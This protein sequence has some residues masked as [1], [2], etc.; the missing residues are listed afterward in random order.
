VTRGL[1]GVTQQARHGRFHRV[2]K[3][4]PRA[5]RSGIGIREGAAPVEIAGDDARQRRLLAVADMLAVGITLVVC[6]MVLGD[7][8]LTL[9]SLAL[10]PLVVL[11]SAALRLYDRDEV[12]LA[13]TTLGEA[14]ALFQIATLFALLVYLGQGFFT[15]IGQV[16][17]G[18]G[19]M[20]WLGFFTSLTAC[21]SAMRRLAM[22]NGVEER[23]LIV[24]HPEAANTVRSKLECDPL[25]LAGVVAAVS[26]ARLPPGLEG[27]A[28]LS[29]IV[30]EERIHRVIVASLDLDNEDLLS[31]VREMKA[32]GVKVT[33]QPRLLEV[34]GTAVE[35]DD[36]HGSVFLGVRRFGLTRRQKRMKRGLD[37]LGATLGLVVA[38]PLLFAIALAVKLDSR[39]PVLFRQQRV[40]RGGR[41]FCI[42]KF[43]T[44]TAD[45]DAR[46]AALRD[47][48]EAGDGLFKI[49]DDPRVT[50]V[51]RVLR[52]TSLDEL[53]QLLNVLRGEMSL[54]GPR[55]LIVDEDERIEG[56]HRRRLRLT[57]GM[58]GSWQVLGSARVPLQ[59]MVALDY[60]YIVNWSVWQDM[61]ILLRTVGVVLRRR[62]L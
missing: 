29:A 27:V 14:P 3:L 24:G 37:T 8:H 52:R 57:P 31:L 20:L 38:S 25:T 23:C 61:Q 15:D 51:G 49:R 19:L 6:V 39:G 33:I 22:L 56:W 10:F 58:T 62:G 1:D 34:V 36:I 48:N 18:Q 11:V 13:K 12:R 2:R 59:E 21:R 5:R 17:P 43:R 26:P 16:G 30:R 42:Y 32:L 9:A 40:G 50:R 47:A 41:R 53:P 35:F 45:A 44:M 28:A 55:P 4:A 54:V 46:K 7:E 60:L